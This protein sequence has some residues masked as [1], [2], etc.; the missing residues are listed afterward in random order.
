M[1]LVHAQSNKQTN[2]GRRHCNV[3]SNGALARAPKYKCV[4]L[5]V[6]FGLIL[7]QFGTFQHILEHVGTVLER[8]GY[9]FE[10]SGTKIHNYI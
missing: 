4:L 9:I 7:E 6:H 5:L 8:F 10:Q 1:I 2:N 3:A